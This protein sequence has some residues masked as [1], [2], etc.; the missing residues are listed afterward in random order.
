ML[1]PRVIAQIL[2]ALWLCCDADGAAVRFAV[3]GDYGN[4]SAGELSVANLI[5]T[6]FQPQFIVTAGDNN[7]GT[8]AQIDPSIGKYYHS[9]IGNY[10]GTFGLG[11]TSN[12]FFPALGN[13]DFNS[14]G[15]GAHLSYFTLP[16]NERY[17]Y[18]QSGPVENF[19]VQ[20]RG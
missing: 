10:R 17:Y 2:A 19:R 9:Y 13:H 1:A 12:R 14:T 16:G 20:Q 7:Y 8:A 11:A 4:D 3:I 18:H 6:N 5:K 15:Y